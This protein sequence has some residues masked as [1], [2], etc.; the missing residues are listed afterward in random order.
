MEIANSP[1]INIEFNSAT[2]RDLD[3][4]M[5]LYR[6]IPYNRLLGIIL[7]EQITFTLTKSWE[8]VY[9]N[10]L[11]KSNFQY[12]LMGTQKLDS[13]QDTLYGLC[14]TTKRESDAMWRI[15]S[16]DKN[17]V[18]IRTN[19]G[20]IIDMLNKG[21]INSPYKRLGIRIGEVD[22]PFNY[23]LREKYES[24]TENE[25]LDDFNKHLLDSMFLK[26]NEFS[27]EKE[28]RI[29]IRGLKPTIK[30]YQELPKYLNFSVDPNEFIEKIAFD[31]RLEFATY[32]IL[33]DALIKIGYPNK[34]NR[35][36]RTNL[37]RFEKLNFKPDNNK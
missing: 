18:R 10:F 29:I 19:L 13:Y 26:R 9:E 25:I 30:S 34:L 6:V 33:K 21:P 22:Y 28:F 15:Y 17:S 2:D 20:Y 27:H 8:D 1:I 11:L 14:F 31:P 12:G 24:L 36:T 16:Q 37:Y 32:K 5:P 7:K 4:G 3:K 23:K 35:I